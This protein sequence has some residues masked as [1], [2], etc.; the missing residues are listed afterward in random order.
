MQSKHFWEDE[1]RFIFISL[2][3][4]LCTYVVSSSM[5]HTILYVVSKLHTSISIDKERTHNEYNWHR[6]TW[7]QNN[8]TFTG[9]FSIYFGYFLFGG[10][11]FIVTFLPLKSWPLFWQSFHPP[12]STGEIQHTKNNNNNNN[13]Q[14]VTRHMSVNAYSYIYER[15][16]S[17]A[18]PKWHFDET[19][20]FGDIFT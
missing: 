9:H 17:Q 20:L 5:K 16:E 3:F 2:R 13:T 12:S 11:A 4:K 8:N 7:K 15:T 1:F 14:L 6:E 18:R 10:L 19:Q